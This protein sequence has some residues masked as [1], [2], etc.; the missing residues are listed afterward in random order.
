MYSFNRRLDPPTIFGLP[1]RSAV[2]VLIVVGSLVLLLSMP[3]P[4]KVLLV[5]FMGFGVMVV[6]KGFK[7]RDIETVKGVIADSRKDMETTDLGIV[8]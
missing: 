7:D 6:V 8:E 3:V 5:L 1:Q 2:G 4:V